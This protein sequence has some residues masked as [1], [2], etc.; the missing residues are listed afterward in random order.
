MEFFRFSFGILEDIIAIWW[1]LSTHHATRFS[2][3]TRNFFK[4][5]YSFFLLL[6]VWANA[7]DSGKFPSSSAVC[8]IQV[9]SGYAS[10]ERKKSNSNETCVWYSSLSSFRPLAAVSVHFCME[11][12]AACWTQC[13]SKK[14]L[15]FMWFSSHTCVCSRLCVC[16][17]CSSIQHEMLN[18]TLIMH[19]PRV[20]V[21]VHLYSFLLLSFHG[22]PNAEFDAFF[23]F[24]ISLRRFCVLC[25]RFVWPLVIRIS[26]K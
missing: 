22:I 25:A 11:N 15:A 23:I 9:A 7:T 10:T 17:W 13:D 16:M 1:F 21:L 8:E 24:S 19:S 2:F 4:C 26:S 20:P 18:W 3:Q 14:Q 12:A 5:F 6:F